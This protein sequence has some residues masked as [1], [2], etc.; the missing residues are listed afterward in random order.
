MTSH[1]ELDDILDY[2]RGAR[3]EYE[4]SN[5][6]SDRNAPEDEQSG[7]MILLNRLDVGERQTGL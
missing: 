7:N 1:R 5:P 4:L 3:S 2:I 6:C